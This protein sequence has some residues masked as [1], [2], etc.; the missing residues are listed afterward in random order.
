MDRHDDPSTRGERPA[1]DAEVVRLAGGLEGGAALVAGTVRRSAGPWRA[2]VHRLLAHLT[3]AGFS[4]APRPLGRDAQGREVLTFL[5][6]TTVGSSRPWPPWVHSEQALRD[7]ARWLRDYHRAVA[8]FVPP[9]DAD[10]REHGAWHP[11]MIVAH[12]D[13]APYNAVWDAEGL[14]GFVDWDMAGPSRRE[15]DVAW[16][17]FSWVPLHARTVVAAEGF[18]AFD[19][20]RQRLA[21]FL[22]AYGWQGSTRDVLHLVAARL[23]ARIRLLRVMA[24]AGDHAYQRM[25]A[26]GRDADLQSALDELSDV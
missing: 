21:T 16:V 18:T 7:V 25:L 13:A 24:S 20:R 10:W 17:A 11:G 5:P 12:N 9:A 22:A 6:G 3:A 1:A 8:D 26:L 4:G 15:D 19:E 14:V 2:S 23:E